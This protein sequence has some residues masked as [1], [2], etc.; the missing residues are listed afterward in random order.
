MPHPD[1]V[2]PAAMAWRTTPAST[3]RV[4]TTEVVMR[5]M[6]REPNGQRRKLIHFTDRATGKQTVRVCF[7]MGAEV[8]AARNQGL[9]LFA[10]GL[11]GAAGEDEQLAGAGQAKEAEKLKAPRREDR[12]E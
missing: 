9:T 12:P 10:L 4:G 5:G 1:Q 3:R 8:L 2:D 7:Q 6:S 11:G